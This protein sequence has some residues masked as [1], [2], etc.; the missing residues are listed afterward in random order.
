M[1]V[2]HNEKP[3]LIW[4]AP[5]TGYKTPQWLPGKNFL[6]AEYWEKAKKHG[7]VRRLLDLGFIRVDLN[8]D[9]PDPSLPPTP[10]QLADFTPTELKAAM[11]DPDVPLA[12]HS[13][14]EAE[15]KERKAE[16]TTTK[17]ATPAAK[18][19]APKPGLT[20]MTVAVALPRIARE[21][22]VDVL[23]AWADVDRRKTIG[24]AV[25]ARLADLEP[26]EDEDEDED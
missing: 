13:Y 24:D 7:S 26:D 4:G 11:T 21:T 22:D 19:S 18:P 3:R 2:L 23:I 9:V 17:P 5:I 14:L 20:G 12:W 10:D 16:P 25:D 15:L 6:D 1:P 8:D